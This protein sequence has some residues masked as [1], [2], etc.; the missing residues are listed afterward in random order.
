MMNGGLKWNKIVNK[1][2]KFIQ[3][4]W[5]NKLIFIEIRESINE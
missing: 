1:F 3:N 5:G 4:E 2:T